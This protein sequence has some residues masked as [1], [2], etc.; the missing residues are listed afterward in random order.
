MAT[1]TRNQQANYLAQA[2]DAAR[3]LADKLAALSPAEQAAILATTAAAVNCPI[4]IVLTTE[5][6]TDAQEASV[7]MDGKQLRGST[8]WSWRISSGCE[9]TIDLLRREVP[10]V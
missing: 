4:D 6:F 8:E 3:V 7:L 1:I 9:F 5:A 2:S 10:H